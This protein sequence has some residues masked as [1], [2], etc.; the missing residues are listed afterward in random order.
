MSVFKISDF[1]GYNINF[2]KEEQGANNPY[3]RDFSL[4]VEYISNI[5][6][7][8]LESF[9]NRILERE[10]KSDVVKWLNNNFDILS[11]G[12]V[13]EIEIEV[14]KRCKYIVVEIKF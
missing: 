10:F 13:E 2:Y 5:S 14:Y 6:I 3:L 1:V 8:A 9:L 4:Q 11:Y 12:R 7:K